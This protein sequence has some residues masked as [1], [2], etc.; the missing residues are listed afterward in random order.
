[1]GT[2]KGS[3]S[4]LKTDVNWTSFSM[5]AFEQFPTI[6]FAFVCHTACLPIFSQLKDASKERMSH[7]N[8]SSISVALM[9][10]LVTG[11]AG[12]LTYAGHTRGTLIMNLRHC[13]GDVGEEECLDS[14]VTIGLLNAAF[15]AAIVLGYP[16]VHFPTRRAIIALI[17]GVDKE[18]NWLVHC[19]VATCI[20]GTTL[21]IA[22]VC[23]DA[24]KAFSWTGSIASPL[25]VF[26]LPSFYYQHLL[27][28][29][30]KIPALSAKRLW[31]ICVM[32]FGLAFMGVCLYV[33]VKKLF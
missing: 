22:L 17:W 8:L 2:L 21:A 26:I 1:M 9:L 19:G 29:K 18:F 4:V 32:C 23:E 16:C 25:I 6:I 24:S 31:P 7:V 3:E 11:V 13:W 33:K 14:K 12:Y 5:E 28:S 27:G 30:D 10:Y 15:L 20:V